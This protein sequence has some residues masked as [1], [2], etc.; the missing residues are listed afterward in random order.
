MTSITAWAPKALDA[1]GACRFNSTSASGM[2]S[3]QRTM[4][5][6]VPW[7]KAGA[8]PAARMP[9][10][11]VAAMPAAAAPL[12][13][14]RRSTACDPFCA[15]LRLEVVIN[16]SML[17]GRSRLVDLLQLAFGPLYRG[18]R[19]HGLDTLGLHGL[20]DGPP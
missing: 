10:I 18:F 11:P 1:S 12:R 20:D 9:S 17:S 4:W 16:P 7:A 19:L 2:K 3:T 6:L 13:N 5:T 15:R 8:R 14:A